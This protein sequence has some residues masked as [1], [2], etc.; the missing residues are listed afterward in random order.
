MSNQTTSED[1]GEWIECVPEGSREGEQILKL[2]SGEETPDT[3]GA[4]TSQLCA[5]FLATGRF[6]SL[7]APYTTV[8]DAWDRL[9][10]VQRNVVRKFN[11]TFRDKKW[12]TP[13]HY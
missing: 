11:P 2:L 5:I 10:S 13:V 3:I 4:S 1:E 7:P 6:E 8:V 9:D 12:D